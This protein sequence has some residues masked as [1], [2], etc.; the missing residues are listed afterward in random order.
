VIGMG[1]ASIGSAITEK[2]MRRY[3]CIFLSPAGREVAYDQ[4]ASLFS[5]LQFGND[6]KLDK[7]VRAPWNAEKCN[8]G[9]SVYNSCANDVAGTE[10]QPTRASACHLRT[11]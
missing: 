10:F 9:F 4:L 11:A 8:S 2:T 1:R 5:C 7:E 6:K 3:L